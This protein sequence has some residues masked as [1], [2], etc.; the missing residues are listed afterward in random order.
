MTNKLVLGRGGGG[1]SPE[2]LTL[3][4]TVD[5]Q[6]R[7]RSQGQEILSTMVHGN[8]VIQELLLGLMRA[9]QA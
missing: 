4:C 5:S 8:I 9:S 2:I 7:H 1:A 6:D 3:C